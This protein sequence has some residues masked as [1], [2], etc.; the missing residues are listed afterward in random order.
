VADRAGRIR[1][2]GPTALLLAFVGIYI[3]GTI[4]LSNLRLEEF[5]TSNWDLGI[6]QQAFWSTFHGHPLYEAGDWEA[7]GCTSLLEVHPGIV[8]FLFVP[9]Y[10]AAPTPLTLF[11]IQS[12]AAGAAALPLYGIGLRVFGRPWPSLG[13]AT[14]YLVSAA[15]ITANMY[16]FHLELFLPLEISLLFYCWLTAR[17][18]LGLIAALFALNTIEVAP[19]LVGFLALYFLLPPLR[20]LFRGLARELRAPAGRLRGVLGGLGRVLRQSWATRAGRYAWGLL[21]VAVLAYPLLRLFE[22]YFLPAVLPPAPLPP[23]GA[24][25]SPGPIGGLGLAFVGDFWGN[26]GHKA[27]FWFLMVALFGFLPLFAPRV[28]LLELPWF[29][30]TL[31]APQIAWSTLGFQ[32]TA[33]AVM[34]LAIASIYGADNFVRRFL[35]WLRRRWS[36]SSN[37]SGRFARVTDSLRPRR[38]RL[39]APGGRG[40]MGVAVAFFAIVV[41]ANLAVGPL[42]PGRQTVSGP[43]PGFNLQY[44]PPPGYDAANRLASTIPANG[45]LLASSNLFPLVANRL[46]AYA[47]LWIPTPP[48]Q[49]PFD[50]AHPPDYLFLSS[51]QLY[52]LPP[53]LS[54][55]LLH[56]D[57]G[58]VAEIDFTPV[59]SIYLFEAGYDGPATFY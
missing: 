25:Y 53:W 36:G 46:N 32:Y 11:A 16:D 38:F 41:V 47:L 29:V 55:D 5:S 13:F 1:Y 54:V 12:T 37:R 48:N 7:C 20:P 27:Q 39:P 35:P 21:F 2:P 23:L 15:L 9:F 40:A 18:R 58:L 42:N 44:T 31:Q 22:W 26:L 50:P 28:L 49:L 17:Y 8:L 56:R 30:F 6:F 51:D 43:L 24:S 3:A 52:A 10:A 57:Y 34:P 45:T 19:F 59:G 4:Y 33:I 14:V